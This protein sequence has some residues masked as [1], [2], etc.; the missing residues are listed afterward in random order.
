[1]IKIIL[2][3]SFNGCDFEI[4]FYENKPVVYIFC[5]TEF[6]TTIKNKLLIN[7]CI[8]SLSRLFTC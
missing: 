3:Y 4:K 2:N 8:Y 5:F 7:T 6:N 1:M